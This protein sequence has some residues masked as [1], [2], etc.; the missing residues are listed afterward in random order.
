MKTLNVIGG[1]KDDTGEGGGEVGKGGGGGPQ[2]VLTATR[3]IPPCVCS[4][5]RAWRLNSDDGPILFPV[6]FSNLFLVLKMPVDELI[7]ITGKRVCSKHFYPDLLQ[8][9]LRKSVG[10]LRVFGT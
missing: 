4:C 8:F 7:K 3:K 10:Q 6:N 1:L 9:C 5:Q 2:R